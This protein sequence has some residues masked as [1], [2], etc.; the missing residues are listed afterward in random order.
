MR[1]GHFFKILVVGVLVSYGSLGLAKPTD[2]LEKKGNFSQGEETFKGV[3]ETLLTKYIDKNLTK[4]EL[5]MAATQ[6]MLNSLNKDDKEWNKLLSPSEYKELQIDLTG[7]V[8]G[9]GAEMKFEEQTGYATILRTVTNSAAE[10]AGLKVDDQILSVNGEK[11]KGRTFPEMVSAIRGEVGKSVELKVLREDKVVTFNIKR[12]IVPWSSISLEKVDSQTALLTI[13]FFNEE[14]PVKIE[15]KISEINSANYKNL[16]VD[17]RDNSGGAFEPALR[18][19]ELFLPKGSVILKTQDRNGK[20][21][22]HKSVKN[23]LNSNVKIFVLVD[24]NT[25]SSA[26]FFTASLKENKQAKVVGDKTFGKWTAQMVESLPNQYAIKYTVKQF[27]TPDGKS[28][29]DVGFKPDLEVQL[30]S[31]NPP[32]ELKL[33]YSVNKRVDFDS[34]LKAAV[35]LTKNL[36]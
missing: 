9:I 18:T 31:K 34:Q 20:L 11:F 14:T 4:E 5:Y 16:I 15:E 29:Q 1:K 3:M 32:R 28:Y 6:G 8:T 26:E 25:S 33:K 24:K 35:E 21:E 12:E 10:K 13:G 22:E 2:K 36:N 19:I 30:S 17:L 27:L 23:L 7:K